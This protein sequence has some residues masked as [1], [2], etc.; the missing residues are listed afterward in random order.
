M[1]NEIGF[2]ARLIG[3]IIALIGAA[4]G[5]G[6][7]NANVVKKKGLYNPDGSLIYFTVQ[8]ATE[9]AL[10]IDRKLD[11]IVDHMIEQNK[12]SK[13]MANFVGS[14]KQYMKDHTK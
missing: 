12:E 13:E 7:Y 6:K 4:F 14:V 2:M 11:K 5:L 3:G 9:Q 8:Q 10:Q 1:E